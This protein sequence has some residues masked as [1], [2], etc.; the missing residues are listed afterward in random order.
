MSNTIIMVGVLHLSSK[1]KYTSQKNTKKPNSIDYIY[2]E[3]TP[4]Y[5]MLYLLKE[6]KSPLIV[7]KTRRVF[8]ESDVYV[9]V[10]IEDEIK[11]NRIYGTVLEYFDHISDSE[12]LKNIACASWNKKIDKTIININETD[13]TPVRTDL[14]NLEIFSIDPENCKDIDDALHIFEVDQNSYEVGIHIADVSSFISPDNIYDKELASRGSSVYYTNDEPSYMITKS[15]TI[16]YLSL[17]EKTNK[18]AFSLLLNIT[19]EGDLI[20]YKFV[21]SLIN[22]K[23]NLSYTEALSTL[24]DNQTIKNL[25]NLGKNILEKQKFKLN[26]DNLLSHKEYDTHTMVQ[27]YM[28][29]ANKIVAEYIQEKIPDKV[30]LRSFDQNNGYAQYQLG[31]RDSYHSG[32]NLQYYTHF[33][34]PIRRY[35]DIVVHRQ[36]FDLLTNQTPVSANILDIS[37]INKYM[38]HYKR[39]EQYSKL[40]SVLDKLEN[41]EKAIVSDIE[42]RD[43]CYIINIYI[44][45]YDLEYDIVV[46]IDV[47]NNETITS[48]KR[49]QQIK[50]KPTLLN[51]TTLERVGITIIDPFFIKTN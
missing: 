21:K 47:V 15:F 5:S 29:L 11:N 40:L 30:L 24:E 14:T 45:K 16:D 25:F 35:A 49:N 2:K 19:K 20:N 18:R 22:V 31:S 44:E 17:I 34:S 7:I 36:L 26:E 3:F 6:P 33:T 1:E 10:Q 39:V 38:R 51:K 37:V 50:I 13:L 27:V 48:L 23:K 28:I 12:L 32:L 43:N 42:K 9:K 4:F 8:S 46:N 41:L